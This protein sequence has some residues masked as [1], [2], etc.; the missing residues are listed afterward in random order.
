ME[1]KK[2]VY[3]NM[4]SSILYYV[5][6][7][8]NDPAYKVCIYLTIIINLYVFL[9]GSYSQMIRSAQISVFDEGHPGDVTM[10]FGEDWFIC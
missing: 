1:F 6:F 4:F 8:L 7:Y 9:F 5:P 10:M 3:Y 2:K